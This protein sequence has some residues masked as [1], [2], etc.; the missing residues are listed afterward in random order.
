MHPRVIAIVGSGTTGLAAALFLHRAGHRVTLF[1]QFE[2]PRP[3]GAGLLLQ[4]TGLAV[5]A[6]LGLDE[7]I[8][9]KGAPVRH[10]YGQTARG[11][12]IF[13]LHY[14]HLA[15][16][17][18][19]VGIHRGMLFHTLYQEVTRLGIP[20][21][22]GFTVAGSSLTGDGTRTISDASGRTE[23]TFDLV[24]DAS[25]H[26]SPLRKL[27]TVRYH[28]PCPYA[29]VWGV[30]E[31]PGQA[32]GGDTLAQ[33]YDTARVMIGVLPIG[34]KPD[35]AAKHVAFF[36]SLPADTY[37]Q[38]RQYGLDVWKKQ[39]HAYWP[40]TEC[41][42]CQFETADDLTFAAY[43]DLVMTSWHGEAI[44]FAGDSAHCTSPQLGQGAN[45]GLIDALTLARCLSDTDD[46]PEALA[47]YSKRRKKHVRFY[48]TA[49]RWLTPF[50]Q[51][52]RDWGAKVRDC[53]FDLLCR[54]PYVKTQML[55]TLAGLKTG[56]FTSLDPGVWHASYARRP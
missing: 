52:D 14:A 32:F 4:P 8:I 46:L 47:A 25:G 24:I 22:T 40:E 37:A 15:P 10:L 41:F 38:W 31:D 56:L 2:T 9:A 7:I 51:S 30:C 26:K 12:T 39:V 42:T 53:S 54:T 18:F 11:R 21:V 43:G 48:Q 28:K 55:E 20:V 19:G 6:A 3:I 29:A 33:R 50:F 13:N 17:Y 44:A 23:G 27:G 35:N 16:H 36:W 49:S 1:E 5:L 34:E 45:L